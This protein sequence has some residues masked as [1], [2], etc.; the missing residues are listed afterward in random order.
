VPYAQVVAGALGAGLTVAALS[1]SCLMGRL[2]LRLP[3]N[4]TAAA[5]DVEDVLGRLAAGGATPARGS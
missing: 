4:R 1:N 5:C 3:Y 2:L